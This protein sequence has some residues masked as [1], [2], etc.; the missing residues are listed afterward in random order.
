[1]WTQD[2]KM[3]I[4]FLSSVESTIFAIFGRK[5]L[6]PRARKFMKFDSKAKSEIHEVDELKKYLSEH[7]RIWT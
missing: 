1:M 5:H 6:A 3:A 4:F 7:G 2:V